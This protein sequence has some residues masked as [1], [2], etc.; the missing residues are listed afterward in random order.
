MPEKNTD[1]FICFNDECVL[2]LSNLK[3][4]LPSD[5]LISVLSQK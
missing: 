1:K 3:G 5:T 2:L 4:V